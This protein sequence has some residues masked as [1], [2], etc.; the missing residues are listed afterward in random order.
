MI[1]GRNP[2]ELSPI[3]DQVNANSGIE[4]LMERLYFYQIPR[5]P[6]IE[7]EIDEQNCGI[8]TYAATQIGDRRPDQRCSWVIE[9]SSKVIARAHSRLIKDLG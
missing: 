2:D 8:V 9:L 7:F 5:Y 6:T 3:L 4:R 1:D